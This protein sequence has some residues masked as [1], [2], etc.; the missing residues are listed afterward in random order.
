MGKAEV[1]EQSGEFSMMTSPINRNNWN[2]HQRS[3]LFTSQN[4]EPQ[5]DTKSY[6]QMAVNQHCKEIQFN[7]VF[8]RVCHTAQLVTGGVTMSDDMPECYLSWKAMFQS[9]ICWSWYDLDKTWRM[10]RHTRSDRKIL[11]FRN[12]KLSKT[13]TEPHKLCELSDFL[14]E[15]EVVK[16]DGFLPSLSYVDTA[17]GVSQILEKL[18][19]HHEEK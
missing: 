9:N 2:L 17:R 5:I 6:H 16:L 13:V 3:H 10:L 15:L 1:M 8:P 11:V 7:K 14:Y 19:F 12:R 4:P 18:P